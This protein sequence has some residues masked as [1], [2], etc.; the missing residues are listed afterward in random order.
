MC[1]LMSG[2]RGGNPRWRSLSCRTWN[3]RR[4]ATAAAPTEVGGVGGK[5]GGALQWSLSFHGDVG[6]ISG[7]GRPS[8]IGNGNPL[9]FSCLE[10]SISR[11]AWRATDH[12]VPKLD[13]TEHACSPGLEGCRQSNLL[14]YRQ[15]FLFKLSHPWRISGIL[16]R[17]CPLLGFPDGSEDE[18]SV[19]NAGDLGS[20]PRSGRS[21][22][23]GNGNPLQYS[24]PE[25]STE[26]PGRLQSMGS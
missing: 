19:C 20:N 8:E 21:P 12:S 1:L 13:T 23:E 16:N 14:T 17:V 6:L 7:W 24:C 18:V 5:V 26:E 2:V 9:Q 10:N 11:G 22:G 4:D 25:N 3:V 15:G